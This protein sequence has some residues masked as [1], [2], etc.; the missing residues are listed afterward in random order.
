MV[1]IDIDIPKRCWDCPLI[2][3]EYAYCQVT[4]DEIDNRSEKLSD[5]PIKYVIMEPDELDDPGSSQ[6]VKLQDRP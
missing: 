1:V 3:A 5:C 4:G 2:N 6:R